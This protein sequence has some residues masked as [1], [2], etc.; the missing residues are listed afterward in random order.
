MNRPFPIAALALFAVL[1]TGTAMAALPSHLAAQMRIPPGRYD[2]AQQVL[3]LHGAIRHQRLVVLSRITGGGPDFDR[4]V[5]LAT[6]DGH[7]TLQSVAMT[8]R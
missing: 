8:G 7:G 6:R 2:A 1:A 4:L 5:A 3:A